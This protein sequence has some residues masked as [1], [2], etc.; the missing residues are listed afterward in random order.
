MDGNLCIYHK[1]H[2][3]HNFNE[4]FDAQNKII[5]II[6]GKKMN[7][8]VGHVRSIEGTLADLSP[9]RSPETVIRSAMPSVDGDRL[10]DHDHLY[11]AVRIAVCFAL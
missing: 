5:Y 3:K 9:V 10:R 6:S 8:R 1:R 4:C 11:I 2:R 7:G